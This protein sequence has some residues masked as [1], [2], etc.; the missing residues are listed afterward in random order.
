M[1]RKRIRS[2]M[3]TVINKIFSETRKKMR[4]DN[5]LANDDKKTKKLEE[6]GS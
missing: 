6:K 1:N 5:E 4:L 2:L 3:L